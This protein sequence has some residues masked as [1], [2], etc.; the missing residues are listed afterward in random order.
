MSGTQAALLGLRSEGKEVL[1]ACHFRKLP[2][3]FYKAACFPGQMNKTPAAAFPQLGL[4][5]WPW[6]LHTSPPSLDPLACFLSL[7]PHA[8]KPPREQLASGPSS[9]LFC[10][11][12]G[13]P[14]SLV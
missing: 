1:A 13:V 7:G 5:G 3:R 14:Y 4:S 6:R 12:V 10:F 9:T 11:P 8:N 2:G